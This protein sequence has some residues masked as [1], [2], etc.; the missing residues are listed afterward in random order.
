[1]KAREHEKFKGVY[2]LEF[3]DH[4]RR[5]ATVS[6]TPGVKTYDEKLVKIE[7]KEYRVWDPY[8]SKL[9]AAIMRGL[10]EMPVAPGSKVLYLGAASG[11]TASHISDIVGPEGL[12]YCIEFSSR[13]LRDLLV[14]CERRPNMVPILADAT[15]L[16]Q[17]RMVVE[18]VDVVYQDV[19]Q[20]E[21]TGILLENVRVFLKRGGYAFIAL[22]A[23]S[24]DVT[25]EPRDIFVTEIRKLEKELELV[26]SKLISPYSLDHAVVLLK[27]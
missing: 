18:G 24:I 20:L 27:K 8:R 14:N 7:G 3:D 11:T 25:K 19:A 15:Q 5:L 1:M 13:S 22:K 2:E 17:Y 26:D 9:S 12:V 6:M 16:D 10:R 23:R 4:S 21:Q